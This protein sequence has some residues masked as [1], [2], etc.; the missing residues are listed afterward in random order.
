MPCASVTSTGSLIFANFCRLFWMKFGSN[1]E[2]GVSHELKWQFIRRNWTGFKYQQRFVG[3]SLA[4]WRGK[5]WSDSKWFLKYKILSVD[6][7][8]KVINYYRKSIAGCQNKA[9]FSSNIDQS[10]MW[11]FEIW[12]VRKNF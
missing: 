9:T 1:F 3:I 6:T 10:W 7:T 12:S 11:M 2:F 8:Q 4:F 5:W